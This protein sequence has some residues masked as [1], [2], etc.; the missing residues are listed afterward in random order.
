MFLSSLSFR[1]KAILGIALIEALTLSV[2][3]IGAL[4]QM[5]RSQAEL[6]ERSANTATSL[7]SA[8]VSDAMLSSDIAK[9]DVVSQDLVSRNE[10]VFVKVLDQDGRLVAER[11]DA[12]ALKWTFEKNQDPLDDLHGVFAVSAPILAGK[13]R[14]GEIRL[15]IDNR[16]ARVEINQAKRLA[17]VIAAI[18]A[19]AARAASPWHQRHGDHAGQPAPGTAAIR[20]QRG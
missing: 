7:F 10:A 17:A 11:G 2:T 18:G 20:S 3:I 6:I 9:I 4:G 16:Q 14:I 19:H 15:G 5:E 13:E 1:W 8:A 12:A